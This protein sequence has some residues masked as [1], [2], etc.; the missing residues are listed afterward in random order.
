MVAKLLVKLVVNT[1][2]VAGCR[3]VICLEECLSRRRDGASGGPVAVG[4]KV[5]REIGQ[6]KTDG[7]RCT[8]GYYSDD[9][10]KE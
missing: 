9:T 7:H 5:C 6:G 8:C 1:A 3:V 10:I 2:A 4:R